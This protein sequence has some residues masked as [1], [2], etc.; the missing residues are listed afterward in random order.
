MKIINLGSGSKGN[1]TLIKINSGYILVDCGLSKFKEKLNEQNI[2]L[3]EIKYVFITH[4]HGDHI[5]NI[6]KFDPSI[7][8]T[9][10]ETISV[11]H[12][13]VDYYKNYKFVDFEVFILKT[14]HDAPNAMGFI[15]K[16]GNSELVYMTDTGKIPAKT[17]LFCKNKDFYILE[18]NYDEKLLMSSNRPLFLKNRI[19]S[20]HGHLSNVQANIYLKQFVG[21]NTK[22]FAFAHISEECNCDEKVIESMNDFT[23]KYKYFLKQW[24]P[25]VIDYDEN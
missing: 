24:E 13:I 22:G 23:F 9:G 2:L 19:K 6:L 16:I 3:D 17:K 12:N 20:T 15:F 4:N 25:T 5:L 21:E 8:Y 10:L 1:A 11:A 14:S 18:S 7:I